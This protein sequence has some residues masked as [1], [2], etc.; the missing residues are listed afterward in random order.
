MIPATSRKLTIQIKSRTKKFLLAFPL[1]LQLVTS[2]RSDLNYAPKPNLGLECL[3]VVDL[4][5]KCV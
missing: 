5:S 1:N 2:Q 4:L 3:S